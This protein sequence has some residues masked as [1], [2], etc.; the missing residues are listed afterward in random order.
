MVNITKWPQD[1][2]QS[3][4][5]HL[6]ASDDPETLARDL[7]HFVKNQPSQDGGAPDRAL[8]LLSNYI[9]RH[10]SILA[11]RRR[12]VLVEARDALQR[13]LEQEGVSRPSQRSDA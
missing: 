1:P 3:H 4:C 10:D 7:L 13:L 8:F 6:F 2:E 11:S 12:Q 9:A 5:A